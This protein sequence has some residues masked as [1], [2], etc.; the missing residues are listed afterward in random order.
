MLHVP[1]LKSFVSIMRTSFVIGV[2]QRG[3]EA[4]L[5]V[6]SLSTPGVARPTT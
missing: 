5:G 6:R 3:I 4:I 2:I 1:A